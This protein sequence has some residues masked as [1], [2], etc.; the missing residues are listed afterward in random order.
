MP[1]VICR[2]CHWQASL[3]LIVSACAVAVVAGAADVPAGL[4]VES[5]TKSGAAAAAGLQAGD[6]LL[7]WERRDAGGSAIARGEFASPLELFWVEREQGAGGPVLLTGRRGGRHLTVTVRNVAAWGLEARPPLSDEDLGTYRRAA[8]AVAGADAQS[9]AHLWGELAS[10]SGEDRSRAAW[11]LMKLG[12]ARAAR[13]A[14]REAHEAFAAAVAAAP[15]PREQVT[16]HFAQA[17]TFEQ[18]YSLDKA[19]DAYRRALE[20]T[21]QHAGDG[22]M[23]AVFMT[24]LGN[25]DLYKTHFEAAIQLYAEALSIR[26]RLAPGS[27]DVA[28]TLNNIASART[29]LGDHAAAEALLRRALELTEILA[30]NGPRTVPPLHN[31]AL[32]VQGRGNL[33]EAQVLFERARAIEERH[34]PPEGSVFLAHVL[35][36]LGRVANEQRDLARALQLSE[37]SLAV[38]ERVEPEGPRLAEVLIQVGELAQELGDLDAAERHLRRALDRERRTNPKGENVAAALTQLAV[39]EHKRGHAD[40]AEQMAREAIQIYDAGAYNAVK[41]PLAALGEILTDVGRLDEAKAAYQRSLEICRRLYPGSTSHAMALESLARV[42]RLRGES[43]EAL[44]LCLEALQVLDEQSSRLGGGQETRLAFGRAFDDLYRETIALLLEQN[45]PGEALHVLERSRARSFLAL[46]ADRDLMDADIP[47]ELEKQRRRLDV[48]YDRAQARLA[49]LAPA[50]DADETAK[51]TRELRELRAR[52]A[53]VANEIRRKSPRSAALRSPEALDLAGTRAALDPGTVLLSFAVAQEGTYLFVVSRDEEPGVRVHRI[54]IGRKALGEKVRAFRERIARARLAELSDLESQSAELYDLLL[55]PA[56]EAI[57]KAERLVLCPDGPLHTLPFAALRRN[58]R[59]L[60]EDKPLH[61][62]VSA[63]VYAQLRQNGARSPAGTVVAFGDPHYPMAA[64]TNAEAFRDAALREG[65]RRG[66]NL[67]A[68]PATRREAETIA[69]IYEK[70]ARVF[71]G[72]AATEERAKSEARGARYVHFACHGFVDER[73]PLNS[74]L[75][76]S[77]RAEPKEGEDNG[78]LQAWEVFERVRLDAELVTLSA[79]DS[80][81]GKEMGGEGLVGLTRA[82]QYAGARSVLASLWAVPDRSTVDLMQAFYK[83]LR[84]GLTKD[85]ALRRAQLAAIR[86]GGVR[87]RPFRW[88]GFQLFGDWK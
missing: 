10:A 26:E 88:A 73:L 2:A 59:H 32:A 67:T 43:G 45:R 16:I 6:V 35:Y 57:A 86:Q 4:V 20:V 11:L 13:Q 14:W 21:R 50:K 77:M 72:A 54:A 63:T 36:S 76:L 79:C 18:E 25:V 56:A 39:V 19:A 58:E 40:P 64:A 75:A 46:L 55:K 5:V 34:A 15:G 66:L 65:V 29:L 12:Q 41:N 31:L 1:K 70:A 22:L 47:A 81:L 83:G 7:S 37:E 84:R 60:V 23:A 61:V 78:L 82:F 9:G 30:P 17:R 42:A 71:V 3:L 44:R 49:D 8:E 48:A 87:S 27:W 80:G 69:R 68:L 53:E 24:G 52:Q 62:V 38:R 51:L 74:G 28:A 85:E 33:S